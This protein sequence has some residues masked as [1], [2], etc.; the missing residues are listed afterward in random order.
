MRNIK[1]RKPEEL[2]RIDMD[3]LEQIPSDWSRF[4]A[5]VMFIQSGKKGN[6]ELTLLSATQNEGVVPKDTL[7][8]V[9]QVKEDADLTKFKT[10][11]VGDFVISLRSFQGGFEM[12]DFEGVITPAYT[13]FRA[14]ETICH[15]YF[16]K[17]FKHDGMISKLNSLTVGI[18]EGKNIQFEDFANM[19]IPIPPQIEQRRIAAFLDLKIVRFD[20]LID[21][22]E[23]LIEKLEEAKKSLIREVITDGLP[24]NNGNHDWRSGRVGVHFRIFGGGTPP[25]EKL[26]YWDGLIPWVSSKDMKFDY[27]TDSQDHI[28]ESAIRNSAAKKV[29][30][31]AMLLVMRSGILRN[32]I[33][34]A[35]N[36]IE[37]T[38]NQD[39]KA[40]I[41][42]GEILPE[43][44]VRFI[45]GYE[46]QLLL[47]WRMQGATVESLNLDKIKK[48]QLRFPDIN[49]QKEILDWICKKTA[50]F[51]IA[52]SKN[53]KLVEK[54]LSARQS[55]ISEAVTG[56]ID[57][58]DWELNDESGR[59][60]ET[61]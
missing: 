33:P 55:L 42:A 43:F 50:Q 39:L 41:R 30:I 35:I 20:S 8:G 16:K 54:Y 23:R 25:T 7:E 40:F 57:L 47:D 38:I 45:Q 6:K 5:K 61:A 9:V 32:K 2:E 27:I 4:R 53:K 60:E 51:D 24:S 36:R 13:V 26:S 37:V 31:G 28:T 58:R 18:R 19:I 10:V 34:V 44:L 49:T 14:R 46:N 59:E 56:K 1:Y 17:L 12:S 11:H 15:R 3:W 52:I 29:P 22:K 48:T 21:K